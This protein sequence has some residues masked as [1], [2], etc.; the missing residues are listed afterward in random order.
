MIVQ[1]LEKAD[2]AAGCERVGVSARGDG[3]EVVTGVRL[4]SLPVAPP[5]KLEPAGGVRR[6][7]GE[8]MGREEP[9]E[10]NS[11]AATRGRASPALLPGFQLVGAVR[12][13]TSLSSADF[14]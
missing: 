5:W 10:C 4:V 9:V 8:P 1:V 12:M 3:A 13:N 14:G 11:A 7:V 6:I 2:T